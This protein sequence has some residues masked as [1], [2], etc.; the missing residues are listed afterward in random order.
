M[1]AERPRQRA[2]LSIRSVGDESIVLDRVTNQVHQLNATA[3][4]VW[5]R[6]DGRHTAPQ[7]ADELVGAFDVDPATAHDAVVTA[8][9]RFDELGLL[10][11]ESD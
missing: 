5:Q 9:R 11:A 4:F 7:I 8:L 3:A 1:V 10:A 6:C 2:D